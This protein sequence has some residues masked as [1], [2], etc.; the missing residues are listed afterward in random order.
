MCHLNSCV[1][2]N[3]SAVGNYCEHP[4]FMYRNACT[5]G[6]AALFDPDGNDRWCG[7]GRR[8]R[9]HHQR[10]VGC[11]VGDNVVDCSPNCS[12]EDRY[13]CDHCDDETTLV[14]L[15]NA[16]CDGDGGSERCCC[17]RLTMANAEL[18]ELEELDGRRTTRQADRE[19]GGNLAKGGF[20]R[21]NNNSGH[22]RGRSE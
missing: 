3:P 15:S 6:S 19:R 22:R 11:S 9:R 5:T 10:V 16:H 1:K 13:R 2:S 20:W 21:T 14:N 18:D 8:R 4:A 12:C 7:S 17:D